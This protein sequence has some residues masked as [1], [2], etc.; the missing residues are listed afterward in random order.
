MSFAQP[1]S[2]AEFQ[3]LIKGD[4]LVIVDF[5]A[6]WCGPCKMI[7]PRFEKFSKEYTDAIFAKVDVDAVPDIAGEYS[8]RAMPTFMFFKNG[9]KVGDVV[10]A[11][12]ANIENK[13]KELLA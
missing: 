4:K 13:I 2:L 3:E 6:T 9:K 12:A 5:W 11:N 10:G 1:K 7:A 8:V